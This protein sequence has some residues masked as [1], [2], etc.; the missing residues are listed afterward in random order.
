MNRREIEALVERD[1]LA[2]DLARLDARTGG[3]ATGAAVAAIDDLRARAD[4]VLGLWNETAP[5]PLGFEREGDYRRRVLAHVQ[6]HSPKWRAKDFSNTH[7]DALDVAEGLVYADAARAAYDNRNV[8]DGTLR[9]VRERDETGRLITR[10]VGD[11]G[12]WMSLFM[13]PG[14]IGI[15]NRKA[16]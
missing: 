1:R 5:A 4:S 15:V 16:E 11:N 10:W 13:A 7:R 2:A 14:R 6:Q 3:P 8:P 9:A 12:A